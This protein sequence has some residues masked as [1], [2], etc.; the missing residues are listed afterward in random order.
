MIGILC[1]AFAGCFV[2][3]L[4]MRIIDSENI[5][6]AKDELDLK[7][8]V[9]RQA[10]MIFRNLMRY[11]GSNLEGIKTVTFE[12]AVQVMK[13]NEAKAI[14][15]AE[16]EIRVVDLP[17]YGTAGLRMVNKKLDRV[18]YSFTKK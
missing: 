14:I 18:E 9:L 10:G 8:N 4:V 6:K 11:G 2:G 13:K 15:V 17:E 3:M 1:G 7:T 5:K 16:N 12:Q